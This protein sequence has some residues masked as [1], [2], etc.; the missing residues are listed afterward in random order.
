MSGF[1]EGKPP[2]PYFLTHNEQGKW[3]VI[4]G[5]QMMSFRDLAKQPELR[6]YLV[7][8]MT[9]SRVNDAVKGELMAVIK[10]EGYENNNEGLR[11]YVDENYP[12]FELSIDTMTRRN[13]GNG[14]IDGIKA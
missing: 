6:G 2:F 10:N 13:S 3:R 5:A 4:V 14:I 9:D 1:N 7:Q 12:D 11:R 8:M